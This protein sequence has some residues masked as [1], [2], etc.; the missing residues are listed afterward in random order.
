MNVDSKIYI[1]GHRGLVGSAIKRILESRGFTS[2]GTGM[3]FLDERFDLTKPGEQAIL[4][5]KR[6][7]TETPCDSFGTFGSALDAFLLPA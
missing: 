4:D 6:L 5:G 3:G 2:P 7:E 1:A